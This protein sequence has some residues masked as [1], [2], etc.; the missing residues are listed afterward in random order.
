MPEVLQQDW[1]CEVN[2]TKILV[3]SVNSQ[4]WTTMVAG[5]TAEEDFF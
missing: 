5:R 2:K 4:V 3:L 1:R